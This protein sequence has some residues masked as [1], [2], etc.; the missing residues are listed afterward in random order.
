MS[1]PKAFNVYLDYVE[2]I[3]GMT[4]AEVGLLYKALLHYTNT[5]EDGAGEL[6]DV[7]PI[8]KVAFTPMRKQIDKEFTAY[9]ETCRARSE[10]GKK[11]MQK[12]WGNDNNSVTSIDEVIT[13]DNTVIT[14][15][16]KTDKTKTNTKTNIKEKNIK[17]EKQELFDR[18]WNAYPRKVSKQTALRAFIKLNVDDVLLDK[19][20]K[21][22]EIQK[23]SDQWQEERFIPHPSTWLNQER[24]NDEPPKTNGGLISRMPT[25]KGF[26]MEYLQ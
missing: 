4:D 18:F 26:G 22:I 16:N 20:L 19:M 17:K 24:W 15:H 6:I 5:W 21:A 11:G 14:E 1:R 3:E 10:A 7:P 12:R 25:V 23:K 8:V 13:K 2:N 9:E